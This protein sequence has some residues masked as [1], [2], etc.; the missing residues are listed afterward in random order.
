MIRHDNKHK[1]F[2]VIGTGNTNLKETSINFGGNNRQDYSLVD[3]FAGSF[4]EI[5]YDEA[6]EKSLT[7]NIVREICLIFREK[8]LDSADV[9]S[10]SLRTMLNF[11]RIFEQQMLVKLESPYA[12]QPFISEDKGVKTFIIKELK[13]SVESFVKTLPPAKQQAVARTNIITLASD[14]VSAITTPEFIEEFVRIHSPRGKDG[15]IIMS[16][17]P[18]IGQADWA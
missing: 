4:Y 12:T 6:L 15:K 8:V 7:Y 11:N 2:C 1:N 9:E 16:V 3:R 17:D 18:K 13:E 5:T 10:I 14:G